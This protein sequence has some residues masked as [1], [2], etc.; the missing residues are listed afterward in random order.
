M[1]S[2]Q[3]VTAQPSLF[4]GKISYTHFEADLVVIQKTLLES[5]G[6]DS[7]SASI[8]DLYKGLSISAD[9]IIEKLNE[10]LKKDLPDGI[11]SLKPEEVTPEATADRIVTGVTG[12]FEVFAKQNSDLSPEALLEKFMSEVRKGVD[13]GYDDASQILD[14]LGAFQFDG[15]KDGIEKTKGLI[16]EKLKAFETQKRQDLGLD[17][18]VDAQAVADVTKGEILKQAGAASLRLVA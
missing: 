10:L 3:S 5:P 8:D 14:N 4:S 7:S 1:E 18:K 12:F 16:E 6:S 17:P 15:V 13:A 2:L 11:Q 9:K